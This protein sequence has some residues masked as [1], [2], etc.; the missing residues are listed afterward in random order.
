MGAAAFKGLASVCRLLLDEHG[1]PR[2]NA[3]SPMGEHGSENASATEDDDSTLSSLRAVYHHPMEL[4]V[5]GNQSQSNSDHASM[6]Q[7]FLESAEVS[8][9]KTFDGFRDDE[10]LGIWLFT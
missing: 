6:V 4:A 3:G 8:P 5:K 9:N 2:D 1:V 10:Q 7:L